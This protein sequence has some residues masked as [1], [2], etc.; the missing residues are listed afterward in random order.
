MEFHETTLAKSGLAIKFNIL[1]DISG[2]HT[3]YFISKLS[4][5]KNYI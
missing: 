1:I 3:Y 4:E 2:A 5:N